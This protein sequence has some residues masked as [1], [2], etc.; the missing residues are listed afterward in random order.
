MSPTVHTQ[1]S[2]GKCRYGTVLIGCVN[3]ELL[4]IML[5]YFP[6]AFHQFINHYEQWIRDPA[7]IYILQYLVSSLKILLIKWI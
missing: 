3:V 7:D 5:N 2:V 1:V 6:K 4:Q